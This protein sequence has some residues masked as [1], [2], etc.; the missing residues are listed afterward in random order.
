MEVIKL[1]SMLFKTSPRD[2]DKLELMSMKH[3]P[4]K[5]YKYMMWCGK[6]IY[7]GTEVPVV[8]EE[9]NTHETI[10]LMQA[11]VKGSWVKYYWSYFVE[12]L[13]GN[14]IIH[15][16]SSA[17]YTIPYEMEAYAYQGNPDYVNNYDGSNLVYFKISNRKRVY[18]DAGGTPRAWK[19]YI[20]R[21][22]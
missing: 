5:G 11:K 18:K 9:S 10:H 7:R 15:P 12:W 4:F 13:K 14:P 16:S 6:L 22:I 8:S 1:I 20:K 19:A 17:Y 3:F 21:T 2:Q